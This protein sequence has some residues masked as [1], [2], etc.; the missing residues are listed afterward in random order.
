[1]TGKRGGGCARSIRAAA[2]AQHSILFQ[3]RDRPE[4]NLL[5]VAGI[6]DRIVNVETV[7]R[8]RVC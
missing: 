5:P 8:I 6:V 7:L 4:N 2:V 3:A 1:M